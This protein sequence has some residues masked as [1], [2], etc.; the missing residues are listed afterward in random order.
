[1]EGWSIMPTSQKGDKLSCENY[2]GICLLNS[3]YKV[4]AQLLYQRLLPVAEG[5]IGEYQA[6]FRPGR[7]TSDQIFTIRQILE[8]CREFNISTYHLFIDFKA[9]YDSVDRNELFHVMADLGFPSKLTRLVR[10]TLTNVSYCVKLQGNYSAPF[11][12]DNG[13]RQGDALSTLLFNVVLEG[14]VRRAHVVTNGTI[15]NR[16]VQLL[17]YAD[18]IDI[19]GRSVASVRETFTALEREANRVGLIVNEN[20]T[21]FMIAGSN[22]APFNNDDSISIGDRNFEI[23]DQFEYLGSTVTSDND[24]SVEIAKRIQKASCAFGSLRSHMRSRVL[25]RETKRSMYKVLIRPV[26]TYGSECWTLSASDEYQLL[27]FERRV[28]R[29]IYGGILENG[30]WRRRHNFELERELRGLTVCGI[31]KLSRLRWAGHVVRMGDTRTPKIVLTRTPEGRR[32]VG[33]PRARWADRVTR[34][35]HRCDGNDNGEDWRT[36]ARDRIVWNSFVHSAETD[37]RL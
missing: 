2:R 23:V 4:F 25:S 24:I 18:D 32:R 19:I 34:D 22:R 17:A 11:R 27:S 7:S 8:K 37:R 33:A 20:K 12:G 14:A 26:L 16:S 10:A 30:M 21:K 1:V 6:G 31:V 5:V 28:L 36:R 29:S 3:A 13:L 9:A 15:F 35:V